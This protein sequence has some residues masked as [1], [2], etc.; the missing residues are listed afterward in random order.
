[1]PTA[2]MTRSLSPAVLRRFGIIGLSLCTSLFM[3]VP[4]QVAAAPLSLA[5]AR[6]PLALPIFVALSEG[7]FESEGVEVKVTEAASGRRCLEILAAGQADLGTAAETAIVFESF[8]RTDFSILATLASTSGDVELVARHT[9]GVRAAKDLVGKR[10][11]VVLGT[12]AQYFLDSFLLA[13]NVDPKTVVQVPIQPEAAIEGLASAQVDAVAIFQPFAYQAARSPR[14]PTVVLSESGEY[15]QIFNLV[16]QSSFLANHSSDV[17]RL[18]KAL[19][20]ANDFIRMQPKRAA[21]V[22]VSRLGVDAGFA[23]WSMS[24]TH[25]VLTLDDSLLRT[26]QSQ[27]KWAVR[28][29]YVTG[30]KPADFRALVRSGPLR[31]VLPNAVGLP[32]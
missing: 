19:K 20:R 27:A 5:V 29:G 10:I 2:M 25:A 17:E 1:M 9:A 23:A 26:L 32:Q 24:H 30:R 22:L 11:G 21:D 15:K 16:G 12:S 8:E 18:L 13:N 4:V 7:Y 3:A 6:S 14:V 28:E 31:A